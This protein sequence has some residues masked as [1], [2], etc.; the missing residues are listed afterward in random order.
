MPILT[1]TDLASKM[2]A[3]RPDLKVIIITGYSDSLSEEIL[4]ENG[5]SEVILKPMILD[6]FSKVIRQVLDNNKVKIE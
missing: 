6:D 1:G 3:I 5:V 2:K 4:A